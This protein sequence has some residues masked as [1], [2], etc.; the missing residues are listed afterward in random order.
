MSSVGFLESSTSKPLNSVL[1][2]P[3][4]S[5]AE[6]PKHLVLPLACASVHQGAL[7]AEPRHYMNGL[8]VDLET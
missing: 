1:D 3:G 4:L 6:P 2:E 8:C 7:V 5:P